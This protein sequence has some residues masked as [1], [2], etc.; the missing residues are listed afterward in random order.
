M[1]HYDM[2]EQIMRDAFAGRAIQWER[3]TRRQRARTAL[4]NLGMAL[5]GLLVIGVNVGIVV[6][7]LHFVIKYW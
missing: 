2:A 5:F 6:V 7:I 4:A 1:N 3:P